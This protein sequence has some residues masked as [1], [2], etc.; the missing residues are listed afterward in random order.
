MKGIAVLNFIDDNENLFCDYSL[1]LTNFE[2]YD[3][4][5]NISESSS[6]P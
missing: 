1:D 2:E 3:Y 6:M 4:C 5:L